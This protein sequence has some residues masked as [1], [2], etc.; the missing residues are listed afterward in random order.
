MSEVCAFVF[1]VCVFVSGV[2]V[3]VSGVCVFV[4]DVCV[5]VPDVW[6]SE[7]DVCV[8]VS[9]RLIRVM[10]IAI[11]SGA[12]RHTFVYCSSNMSCITATMI[13][14]LLQQRIYIAATQ[15][16]GNCNSE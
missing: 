3:S 16:N 2:C 8:F 14:R 15:M 4:F 10:E 6:V 13:P 5:F 11:P 12:R 1:D 9:M 7:S